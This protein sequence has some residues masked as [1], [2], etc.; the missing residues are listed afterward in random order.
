VSLVELADRRVGE[1]EDPI[2][3][4]ARKPGPVEIIQYFLLDCNEKFIIANNKKE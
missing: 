4:R 1:G 2:H 3:T